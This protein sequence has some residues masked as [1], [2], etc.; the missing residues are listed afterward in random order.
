M[1]KLKLNSN[2]KLGQACMPHIAC[3]TT[4]LHTGEHTTIGWKAAREVLTTV[5]VSAEGDKGVCIIHT[6]V[7]I[8][9][10]PLSDTTPDYKLLNERDLL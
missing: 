7:Y 6:D 4:R 9:V 1:L 3:C 8:H 5:H 2:H 10:S